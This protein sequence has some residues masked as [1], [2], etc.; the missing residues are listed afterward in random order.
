[1]AGLKRQLHALRM[2]ALSVLRYGPSA[3]RHAETIWICPNSIVNVI[4][5]AIPR[6][7]SGRVWRGDWDLNIAPIDEMPKV[8]MCYRHWRDGL[9]WEEVG[10]YDL[11]MGL[12]ARLGRADGCASLDDVKARYDRLDQLFDT[13]AKE[14][15]L[16]QVHEVEPGRLRETGGVL[17]HVARDGPI[18]GR[19]GAH[20]LAIARILELPIIP[21][22]LGVVHV[23]AIPRLS[24]LRR[25]PLTR[26]HCRRA[27]F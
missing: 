6:K 10:A 12:I 24:E 19:G 2:D 1:M 26:N 8:A 11:M 23:E 13:A 9:S 15:R 14:R 27:A 21:A 5:K 25:Q 22:K 16:R 18:F 4:A 17:F 20:R 7:E 3:P